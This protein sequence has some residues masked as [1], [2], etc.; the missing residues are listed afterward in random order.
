MHPFV[1]R[2]IAFLC[3]RFATDAARI[4]LI[5]SVDA[6]VLLQ[7]FGTRETFSAHVA[8]DGV[9]A[10]VPADMQDEALSMGE[11]LLAYVARVYDRDLGVHLRMHALLVC[12]EVAGVGKTLRADFAFKGHRSRVEILVFFIPKDK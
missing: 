9:L 12:D 3:K 10:C 7:M 4:W 6:Q 5:P 8:Q 2:Q 1:Q 11:L